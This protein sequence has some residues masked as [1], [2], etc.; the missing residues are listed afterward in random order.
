MKR[1]TEDRDGFGFVAL[2]YPFNIKDALY[3]GQSSRPIED[4][5][6]YIN[7]NNIEKAQVEITD[8][9]FLKL[10]P[11]LQ[12]LR[13]TIPEDF[14]G[15]VDFQGLY[16][17]KYIKQLS[18]QNVSGRRN[19]IVHECSLENLQGLEYLGIEVNKGTNYFNNITTLKSLNVSKYVGTNKDLTNLSDLKELDTLTLIQCKMESLNGI[20][21]LNKIQC[22][23]LYHNRSLKDIAALGEATKTLKALRID[24]CSKIEDFSVLEKLENLELLQLSGNN[25]LPN[26]NFLKGMKNLKTFDFNMNVLDGDLSLCMNI[27]CVFSDINRKQYNIKDEDLPKGHYVRGNEDIEEWRRLE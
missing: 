23:Y 15:K 4:Y 22:L 14:E 10:C 1:Y 12:F 24:S 17:L 7:Y 25:K 26:L 18:L 16:N 20:G 3:I 13:I 11:S 8:L 21:N 27:G 6:D 19:N 5:I 9:D 2:T